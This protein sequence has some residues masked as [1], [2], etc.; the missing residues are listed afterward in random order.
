MTNSESFVG[1]YAILLAPCEMEPV[2]EN[3]FEIA[4]K[5]I[6]FIGPIDRHP[7]V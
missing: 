4:R 2:D 7:S 3:R 5:M 6:A 1:V